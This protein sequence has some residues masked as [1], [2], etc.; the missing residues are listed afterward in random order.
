MVVVGAGGIYGC[1]YLPMTNISLCGVVHSG[2]LSK[3]VI[4]PEDQFREWSVA[5]IPEVKTVEA[6][7]GRGKELYRE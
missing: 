7:A 1:I 6:L 4:M 5:K 2:M 3:V